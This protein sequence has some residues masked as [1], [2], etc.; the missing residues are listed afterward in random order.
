MNFQ[1]LRKLLEPQLMVMGMGYQGIQ[2]PS[3]MLFSIP[4]HTII[5]GGNGRCVVGRVSLPS[6]IFWIGSP[7][8]NV[9]VPILIP[10][11]VQIAY[12]NYERLYPQFTNY[13]FKLNIK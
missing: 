11:E 7:G 10:I 3:N 8:T 12:K 9:S 5:L 1:R 13:Q 6:H 4:H 2:I